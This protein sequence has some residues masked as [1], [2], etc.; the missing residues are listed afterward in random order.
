MGYPILSGSVYYPDTSE[1]RVVYPKSNFGDHEGEGF[2]S[3][4]FVT[5]P[6][7][8]PVFLQDVRFS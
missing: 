4:S 8:S 6:L 1:S 5:G 3:V 7:G 2:G